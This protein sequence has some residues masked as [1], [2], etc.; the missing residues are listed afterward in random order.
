M[1][2]EMTFN[3]GRS[4]LPS[5]INKIVLV[6]WEVPP[7]GWCKLNTDG[8]LRSHFNHVVG[9]AYSKMVVDYG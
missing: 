2:N 9:V 8:A 1:K 5:C 3:R 6:S 7:G 4:V